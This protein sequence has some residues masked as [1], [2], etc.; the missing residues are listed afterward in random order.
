MRQ[1]I[2]GDAAEPHVLR[3]VWRQQHSPGLGLGLQLSVLKAC[4][5]LDPLG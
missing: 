1:Q 3:M 2:A 4:R 5:L